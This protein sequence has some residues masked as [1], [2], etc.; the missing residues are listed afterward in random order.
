MRG[1]T[2]GKVSEDDVVIARLH[3]EQWAVLGERLSQLEV[4]ATTDSSVEA[5]QKSEL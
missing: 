1:V 2:G 3:P 5:T 4:G